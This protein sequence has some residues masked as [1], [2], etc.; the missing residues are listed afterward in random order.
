MGKINSAVMFKRSCIHNLRIT[1]VSKAQNGIDEGLV[2]PESILALSDI[3]PFEQIIVTN[4]RG[5]NWDNRVVSF[6]IPGTEEGLI[7]AR[8]SLAHL[9][10][11]GDLICVISRSYLDNEVGMKSFK[12]DKLALVDVGFDPSSN[13]NNASKDGNICYE[14][15]SKKNPTKNLNSDILALREKLLP[16]IL[17]SHLLLDLEVTETHPDCLQGSAELPGVIMEAAGLTRYQGVHVFN[18]SIGGASETYAVP[19]PPGVVMTT[20]AMANFAPIGTLTHVSSFNMGSSIIAKPCILKISN[21]N[22]KFA[23]IDISDRITDTYASS[24]E[25]SST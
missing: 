14:Y 24:L 22:M 2:I 7:E 13:L 12:E 9:F 5:K 23:R 18:A 17:L 4:I 8:G 21:K 20:G 6:A 11:E 10:R 1:S 16:R 19:M 15:C 25:L 3:L